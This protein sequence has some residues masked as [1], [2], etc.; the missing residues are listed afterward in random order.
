[1]ITLYTDE[2]FKLFKTEAPNRIAASQA[3]EFV[4]LKAFLEDHRI[5]EASDVKEYLSKQKTNKYSLDW[6]ASENDGSL[7]KK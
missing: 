4:S 3:I 2:A 5:L 6:Y 7:S 1:L